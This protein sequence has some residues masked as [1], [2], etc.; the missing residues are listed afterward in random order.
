MK[1]MQRMWTMVSA[2]AALA[3]SL[4]CGAGVAQA[5]QTAP[6]AQNA[7]TAS[8][9]ITGDV[10][11]RTFTAYQ[12][13]T[14]ANAKANEDETTVTS[15]DFN[16]NAAWN[17]A[18]ES[19]AQ[20]E[21]MPA[22]YPANASLSYLTTLT[23]DQLREAATKL[24]DAVTGSGVSATMTDTAAQFDGLEPGYYLVT[25]M[26]N[27]AQSGAPML[28][29][30]AI[31]YNGKMLAS[32]NN[33][34]E[35]GKAVAKP[36]KGTL[37]TKTVTGDTNGT[38]TVGD[39]LTY[40]IAT[41]IP[42]T[43]GYSNYKLTVRDV[44]SEGLTMPSDAASFKVAIDGAP[45]AAGQYTV[46]QNMQDSEFPNQ[47]VTLITLANVAGHDGKKLTVTYTAIV[48]AKALDGVKNSAYVQHNTGE[49]GDGIDSLLKTYGFTFTKVGADGVTPLAGATFELKGDSV[50]ADFSQNGG[51]ATA[52]SDDKGVVSFNGLGAGQYTVKE[53][54]APEG[55]MATMLPTFKVSIDE[56][57][58][59][60]FSK[61]AMWNLVTPSDDNG[62]SAQAT[63]AVKNVK[64]LTQLPLTGAAGITLLVVV[65]ALLAAACMLV[66]MRSR[67]LKKQLED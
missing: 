26:Q 1:R 56:N 7:A 9:T 46:T 25:D 3:T 41:T 48:N 24:A 52:T 18:L 11:D 31:P 33:G 20:A 43:A 55:Y 42:G 49:F 15:V 59:V 17:N 57:G 22:D 30:T 21:H 67:M 47:T 5:E 66:A 14:Y 45:V 27:G 37:P 50:G 35:L 12:L 40:T 61:D 39:K 44:A 64:S 36:N 16:Q 19:A 4:T 13:G 58:N 54:K 51:A 28:V 34:A 60:T 65:A 32:I 6:A 8:I 23:G 10:K 29:G 63:A 62:K 2:V 38:A 53:T